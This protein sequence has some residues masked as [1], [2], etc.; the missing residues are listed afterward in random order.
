MVLF[1]YFGALCVGVATFALSACTM[2]L[3]AYQGPDAGFL[4]T[5]LAVEP[6]YSY[7]NIQF[8]LRSRD[9][10][11]DEQLFWINDSAIVGG[12]ADFHEA[13]VKGGVA[14]VRLKPGAYEFYSFGVKRGDRGYTPRFAYSVPF[15]IESGK[16]TYAGQFLTLGLP[17]EG[18]FGGEVLGAPYFVISNQQARDM[19]IAKTKTPELAALPVISSVAD[20]E[21][22]RVPYFQSAPLRKGEAGR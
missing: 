10:K 22:L 19:A 17:E 5:S 18:M 14:T 8:D 21:V 4:V 6:E 13:N 1:R 2:N 16:S 9:G 15:T 20:P 3:T 12:K 7:D 11:V